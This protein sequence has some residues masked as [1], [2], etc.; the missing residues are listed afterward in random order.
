MKSNDY[1]TYHYRGCK[2]RVVQDE[3]AESPR[4]WDNA[5]TM[6]CWHRRYNLGDVQP[7]ERAWDYRLGLAREVVS[8]KYPEALLIKNRDSILVKHYVILPLY[9]YDHS[10][11]TMSTRPFSCPWD[12]GQ[13]GIIYISMEKAR[14]EWKGTDKEVR[15]KA[16]D[17]LLDEVKTYDQFLT[18]DVYGYITEA[19]NGKEISSCFGY[20]GSDETKEDSY[21][22]KDCAKQ[23]IDAW[24]AKHGPI[25]EPGAKVRVSKGSEG[26]NGEVTAVKDD[27]ISVRVSTFIFDFD[28]HDV[29]LLSEWE[30]SRFSNTLPLPGI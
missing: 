23:S 26:V 13:V 25:L 19:P 20:F 6:A 29:Q 21:M 16:L 5:G 17:C 12:S 10:G 18:G 8:T 14:Q 1:E 9:L 4:E 11:I 30:K 24:I 15:A 7:S 3:D 22:V 2:I 27:V 28:R